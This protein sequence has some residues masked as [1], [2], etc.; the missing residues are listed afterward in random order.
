MTE[1][2][3]PAGEPGRQAA[4][5]AFDHRERGAP[6]V[7]G[8]SAGRRSA[9][10]TRWAGFGEAAADPLLVAPATDSARLVQAS[11]SAMVMDWF[12]RFKDASSFGAGRA[13]RNYVTTVHNLFVSAAVHQVLSS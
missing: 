6:P 12:I 11:S 3:I 7:A 10:S 2:L 9:A 13:C 4:A 8:P 5:A 1:C